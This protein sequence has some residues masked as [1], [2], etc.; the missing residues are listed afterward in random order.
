M[1]A[2]VG[3][4]NVQYLLK[5]FIF[6]FI[7]SVIPYS[8]ARLALGGYKKESRNENAIENSLFYYFSYDFPF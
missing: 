7:T 5:P 8:I 2:T 3:K 4:T 6:E 1:N